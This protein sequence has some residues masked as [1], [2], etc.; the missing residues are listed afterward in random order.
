MGLIWCVMVVAVEGV[1][2]VRGGVEC[3]GVNLSFEGVFVSVVAGSG[4]N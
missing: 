4:L 1:G 3:L 2:G